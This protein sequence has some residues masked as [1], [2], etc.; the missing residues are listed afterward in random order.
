MKKRFLAVLL[1]AVMALSL[2]ACGDSNSNDTQKDNDKNVKQPSIT[3]LAEYKDFSAVLKG[4]Y[5]VT[6][7]KINAYFSNVV[8]S[9]GIGLVEVKD[10]DT[11]QKGDIVKTDPSQ[12]SACQ[13]PRPHRLK[14]AKPPRN[15]SGFVFY[16]VKHPAAAAHSSGQESSKGIY[17][18]ARNIV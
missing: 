12:N 6:D 10:R 2:G 7:E 15:R 11:V 17:S 16:S 5:E 18:F 8:Y 4:N 13:S 9:A 3:K 14:R 1:C